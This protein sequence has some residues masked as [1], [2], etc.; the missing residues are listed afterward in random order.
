VDGGALALSRSVVVVVVVVDNTVW[1]EGTGRKSSNQGATF[2]R[3][4]R[5]NELDVENSE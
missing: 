1:Q 4:Y 2:T 5:Y 3:A